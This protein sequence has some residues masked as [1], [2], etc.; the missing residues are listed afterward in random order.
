VDED[1]AGTCHPSPLFI[2]PHL[3]SH[4][5]SSSQPPPLRPSPPPVLTLPILLCTRVPHYTLLTLHTPVPFYRRRSCSCCRCCC[6]P[7]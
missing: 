4:P 1:D 7:C 3:A 2:F 5:P 6:C